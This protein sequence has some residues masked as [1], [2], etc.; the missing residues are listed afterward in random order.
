[1]YSVGFGVSIREIGRV[2]TASNGPTDH[3]KNK[4]GDIHFT[5]STSTAAAECQEESYQHNNT[6]NRGDNPVKD[7]KICRIIWLACP[8]Q[9]TV[10]LVEIVVP[11]PI[12]TNVG[13]K[14]I[15]DDPTDSRGTPNLHMDRK[16]KRI[17]SGRMR[18]GNSSVIINYSP[19]PCNELKL[20]K[21]KVPVY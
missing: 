18:Y 19:H 9:S 10:I 4:Y 13:P 16:Q 21:K 8:S 14:L 20:A 17:K 5:E 2:D 15:I 1:L 3:R 12:S 7:A 6:G 11:A